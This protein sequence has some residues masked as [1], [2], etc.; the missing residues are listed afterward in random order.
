MGRIH[1]DNGD[2]TMIN[3]FGHL[4]MISLMNHDSRV[5]ENS[6]GEDNNKPPIYVH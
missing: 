6:E 2:K 4:G 1:G 5:R 3:F